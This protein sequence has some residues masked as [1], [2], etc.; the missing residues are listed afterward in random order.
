MQR[1]VKEDVHTAIRHLFNLQVTPRRRTSR[2]V[3][4]LFYVT[5][6]MKR[7]S[8]H[9]EADDERVVNADWSSNFGVG[10]ATSSSRVRYSETPPVSFIFAGGASALQFELHGGGAWGRCGAAADP[11]VSSLS[12]FNPLILADSVFPEPNIGTSSRPVPRPAPALARR[13]RKPSFAR[14]GTHER[15]CR[16]RF[17]FAVDCWAKDA[18]LDY[19]IGITAL[20]SPSASPNTEMSSGGFQL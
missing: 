5:V 3:S 9:A 14:Y 12:L 20:A 17:S 13:V 1:K 11:A 19:D 7:S 4:R 6:S 8:R 10:L 18:T 16:A 15:L 2:Y